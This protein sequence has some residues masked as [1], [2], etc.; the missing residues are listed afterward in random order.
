M[1]KEENGICKSLYES[2]DRFKRSYPELSSA[3]K[4]L[5]RYP[6]ASNGEETFV[7]EY[8]GKLEGGSREAR[9]I[10]RMAFNIQENAALIWA[11]IKDAVSPYY[12]QTIFN[13]L[14]EEFLDYLKSIPEY[15][16]LFGSLDYISCDHCRS[17]FGP[18]AYFADLMRFDNTYISLAKDTMDPTTLMYRRPDLYK[19]RLDCANSNEMI[20]QIDLVNELL[21]SFIYNEYHSDAYLEARDAIFP[22]SLPFNRP[23][24]EIRSY[25]KRYN[26]SLYQ[27]YNTF[28]K[29]FEAH[30]F[31]E[32]DLELA[33]KDLELIASEISS[34][35]DISRFYGDVPLT[36]ID[37]LDNVEVFL[38][39]TRLTRAGLN[40]LLFQNLDRH[41]V[42]A[43]LSRLFFINSADNGLKP[44]S[45]SQDESCGYEKLLNLSPKK[46]DRI[47]RFLK[48]S[49]KLGWSFTDLDWALRSLYEP[50]APEK[51]LKFDGIKDYVACHNYVT[52]HNA[53]LDLPNLGQFTLEA[54]VCPNSS[55]K[56][57]VIDLFAD[58]SPSRDQI[59]LEVDPSNKLSFYIG[60][61]DNSE[62]KFV[63][64][65]K[66]ESNSSL[67]LGSFTHIALVVGN[68]KASIYINGKL[69]SE[70]ALIT[71]FSEIKSSKCIDFNIGRDLFDEYF[72][73]CIKDVRIWTIARDAVAIKE[74]RFRRFT[75]KE[76]DLI[77]YWPLVCHNTELDL[78]K[79]DQFTIEAWVCPDRS[80]KN[81]IMGI[82]ADLNP[83]NDRILLEVNSSNKLFFY[84]ERQEESE[85]KSVESN[86]SLP[87]GTFSHIALVVGNDEASIYIDGRLDAKTAL[88]TPFS[89]VKSG[90]CIDFNI[91]RDLFDE[92]FDGCIKD[93]RIWKIARDSTAIKEDRSNRFTGNEVDLIGY[94]PLTEGGDNVI[95]QPKWVYRDLILDPLPIWEED[96]H[97][98]FNGVDQ[99]LEARGVDI[100]ETREISI[101]A[102][103][104]IDEMKESCIICLSD[105]Y[106]KPKVA[107]KILN[108]S[109]DQG[110]LS[111]QMN[112]PSLQIN[113]P[114][115]PQDKDRFLIPQRKL[116][117]VCIVLKHEP[118]ASKLEMYINGTLSGEYS[119]P[120]Q[121]SM[122][123]KNGEINVGRDLFSH[124]FHGGIR[125]IRIWNLARNRDEITLNMYRPVPSGDPGLVGYWRL[126]EVEKEE[127]RDL[128]CCHN[129]LYLGGL[130]ADYMPIPVTTEVLPRTFPVSAKE[131]ILKFDGDNDV[132]AI[133][134]S[135]NWGLGRYERMT[136]ELW[137]KPESSINSDR[138]QIIFTQGDKEA[139]L[140][141]YLHEAYVYVL[142]W[143]NNSNKKSPAQ[144]VLKAQLNGNDWHHVVLTH[145]EFPQEISESDNTQ[146]EEDIRLLFKEPELRGYLDGKPMTSVDDNSN[147][148]VCKGYRLSS[149]GI[150]YLGGLG[151]QGVTRFEDG[152]SEDGKEYQYFFSGNIAD[153]RIWNSIKPADQIVR[154]GRIARDCYL[155]PQITDDLVTYMPMVKG[156]DWIENVF[157]WDKIPGKDN[158]ILRKFL[159]KKFGIGWVET[160]KIEK[161]DNGK[162][163]KV[164]AEKISLSLELNDEK[165][166]VILEIDDGR[167][168]EFIAKMENDELNIY[169]KDKEW[170]AFGW[171][172]ESQRNP[173]SGTLQRREMALVTDNADPQLINI[174]SHYSDAAALEWN[175]YSYSGRMRITDINAA[176]GVTFFSRHPEGI[177]QCYLLGHLPG[178]DN[179]FR[180]FAHPFDYTSDIE[181]LQPNT[182]LDTI[183]STII[184][185]INI[186]YCFEITVK[187]AGSSTEILAKIW[188]E[189]SPEPK[190]SLNAIDKSDIRIR[191]GTVGLWSS[192]SSKGKRQF[193]DLQVKDPNSNT[194]LLDKNF[195]DQSEKSHPVNWSDVEDRIKSIPREG[196]FKRVSVD[197][198][199]IAFGTDSKDSNIHSYYID[200]D[201]GALSWSNYLYQGRMRI[202]DANGSIGVTF[203]SRQPKEVDQYY[204]L[205]REGEQG[206]FKLFAHPKGVQSIKS[207]GPEKDK[208]DS[209][210]NPLPN[211]WYRFLIK[212]QDDESKM[213]IQ[214]K[215]WPETSVMPEAFQI[216]AYDDSRIRIRSGTV[217]VWASGSGSKYFNDLKVFSKFSISE[218]FERYSEGQDPL[219][220]RDTKANYSNKEDSSLFNIFDVG[221]RK[222]LGTESHE[223][224]IHSHYIGSDALNWSNYV[225]TGKMRIGD[226]GKQNLSGIGVT[227]GIGVTFLSN[228]FPD[229]TKLITY[230]RL[231]YDAGDIE[232]RGFHIAFPQSDKSLKGTV[233]S[234]FSPNPNTWYRF[235]IE[236]ED[237]KDKTIIK[238]KIWPESEAEPLGYQIDAYDDN[239]N[240]LK[241]GTVGVVT[242]GADSKYFDDLE[243][244][245][246]TLLSSSY[247][248]EEWVDVG[249]RVYPK[250]D[251]LF[252]IVDLSN[253]ALRWQV[254]SNYPVLLHPL[255]QKA[256]E[257]DGEKQYLAAPMANPDLSKFTPESLS[258]F[259]LESWI[260]LSEIKA[261]PII[262]LSNNL[263]GEPKTTLK[264][265][266]D[267]I[268]FGTDSSGYLELWLKSGDQSA[269]FKGDS[270]PLPKGQFIHVAVSV[271]ASDATGDR[272][273]FFVDGEGVKAKASDPS[274]KVPDFSELKILRGDIGRDGIGRHFYGKIKEVRI[275]NEALEKNKIKFQM[276][277]RPV[278]SP[279][280]LR[281]W[282]L[283]EDDK[284]IVEDLSPG[285]NPL[286]LGT[287]RLGGM[288]EDR[289]PKLQPSKRKPTMLPEIPL[290]A[291][292]LD[293]IATFKRLKE[294]YNQPIDRL[295][296]LWHSIN[297]VG[298]DGKT[299]LFDRIFNPKGSVIEYWNYFMDEP[300]SWD[301]TG[302]KDRRRDG[303]IRSRLMGALRVS[304]D[305]LNAIVEHISGSDENTIDID[306]TYLWRMYQISGLAGML[307]L[308]VTDLLQLLSMIK[309]DSLGSLHDVAEVCDLAVWASEAGLS[310]ADLAYLTHNP[311]DLEGVSVSLFTEDNIKSMAVNLA[312]QS[313]VTLI[314]NG[315]FA[316][317]QISQAQS[318]DIFDK[319]KTL[320]LIT[321]IG[322]VTAKYTE[323]FDLKDLLS[324]FAEPD[325]ENWILEFDPLKAE[326][327][328][329]KTGLG[330]EIIQRLI[331]HGFIDENG[332]VLDNPK[333]VNDKPQ[334]G[335]DNLMVIFDGKTPD[336][337]TI[338][339][340]SRVT[341][342]LQIRKALQ[343]QIIRTVRV[344]LKKSRD[345]F[346]KAVRSGILVNNGSFALDQISQAQSSDIFSLLYQ[347]LGL[348]TDIG[349]VTAKYTENYDLIDLLSIFASPDKENW[350]KEFDPLKA[351]LEQAETGLGDEI[352]Q[353]LISHGFIDKNG[354]VL[355][356]PKVMDDKPQYGKDNLMVIFDGKTPDEITINKL[357]R[358]VTEILE[359]R[360]ALQAE[361]DPILSAV[362]AALK[363]SRDDLYS[364]I[365]SELANIFN[366]QVGIISVIFDYL[367]TKG[368]PDASLFVEKMIELSDPNSKLPNAL[369]DY[370]SKMSKLVY[371]AGAFEMADVEMKTLLSDPDRFSIS[372][373][374]Q[375]TF[376]DL[377]NLHLFKRLQ[378]DFGDTEGKLMD[379]LA[380]KDT[381]KIENALDDLAGWE[382]RQIKSLAEH[383]V[384]SKYNTIQGLRH[385]KECFDL[386][387]SMQV[388]V[389]YLLQIADTSTLGKEDEHAFYSKQSLGLLEILRAGY[390]DEE[391]PKVYGPIYGEL[392][393]KR[394]DALLDLALQRLPMY[395]E[396]YIF[397]PDGIPSMGSE[398]LRIFLG[399]HL[400]L[401]WVEGA[402]VIKDRDIITV[403]N[404]FELKNECL[405]WFKNIP[406]IDETK[407][408]EY[409]KSD[410]GLDWTEDASITK[411]YVVKITNPSQ[412]TPRQIII[413]LDSAN[414]KAILS[415]N[416]NH[417]P[418]Q[419]KITPKGMATTLSTKDNRTRN[420]FT[421][422]ENG[423][424]NVYD[425]A[426]KYLFSWKDIPGIDETKLKE[427][428]KSDL[429]LDWAEDASIT[430]EDVVKITNP[431]QITPR[432]IT[433]YLDSAN[434][435]A[436]LSTNDNHRPRQVKIT[437]KGMATTLSTNDNRTRNLFTK[438]ENG[439]LNVYDEAG[440]Y[441]FSWKDIPC[442]SNAE[443]L[444]FLKN[445]L[446]L[447]WVEGLSPEKTGETLTVKNPESKQ[448]KIT[449]D[450]TKVLGTLSTDNGLI[451][452]LEWKF[453][454]IFCWNDIPV[455]SNAELLAFLKNDLGL[456]WV[457]GLSPE[458]TGETLTVKNPESKQ[459]K[460]TLNSADDIVVLSTNDPCNP[461]TLHLKIKTENGKLNVYDEAGKYLFSW[462]D[463]P[464]N[465]NA[466]LLAFLKNDLGLSWVEGLSPE[467]TGETLT[468]ESKQVKITLNS[469][470]GIVVLSNN[471]PCNPYTL[472][473]KTKT[474]NG[475][476][477][478]YRTDVY[479]QNRFKKGADAFQEYFLMDMRVGS[480]VLTSRIVQGTAALQYYIQ[481]CLMNLEP[482][483][484]PSTIP[485]Q[486]WEW[487]KNYRVWEANRKVFLYPENYIEPELR[488]T[489]TPL[490][491]ELE[492]EL[493]QSDI[494][495]ESAEAAFT[496][497]LE[498]FAE[499]AN[500]KVVG[501]YLYTDVTNDRSA[502]PTDR[503]EVL[504]LIGRTNTN[505]KIYYR[506]EHI[507][508]DKGARWLPWKKIDLVINS[509]FAT[510]V[511]AFGKLFLF[512]T[513]FT[514][515][516]KSVDRKLSDRILDAHNA[517]SLSN[518]FILYGNGFRIIKSINNKYICGGAFPD[519]ELAELVDKINGV[520]LI[521]FK[522]LL[523]SMDRINFMS[524]I[525]IY[526]YIF[527]YQFQIYNDLFYE[528]SDR[529]ISNLEER[530]WLIDN[531]GYLFN[532]ETD[533]RVQETIDLYKT[534]VKYS[535]LNFSN[536]WIPPQNYAELENELMEMTYREP[537]WQR[538][539]AQQLLE[540]R[541]EKADQQQPKAETD[542][543]VLQIDES[544]QLIKSIPEFDMS[545]LTW[546]FWTK[547][548]NA[549][550]Q[551]WP[552]LIEKDDIVKFV[553]LIDYDNGNFNV[554]ATNKITINTAYS[555]AKA[556]AGLIKEA[557]EYV[558]NKRYQEAVEKAGQARDKALGA[559]FVDSTKVKDLAECARKAAQN[560]MKK[561]SEASA[562]RNNAVMTRNSAIEAR[563]FAKELGLKPEEKERREQIAAR[564]E[565]D[566]TKLENDAAQLEKEAATLESIALDK[567]NEVSD[568]AE[569]AIKRTPKW[570]SKAM[571]VKV[572]LWGGELST[573]LDYDTWQH[574]AIT[575]KEN[576][577]CYTVTL[578]K[579]KDGAEIS[580]PV[581]LT[582]Q[583]FGQYL[584]PQRMLVI[585][586]QESDVAAA[587]TAQMSEFRLWN[588]A[589]DTV[590]IRDELNHR[591]TGKEEGL[592]YLPLNVREA[593]SN[594]TLVKSRGLNLTIPILNGEL[595]NRIAEREHIILFYGDR[596]A[597]LRNNL[598]DKSFNLKLDPK[599]QKN[600][601]DLNLS[602]HQASQDTLPKAVFHLTD[603]IGLSIN[604]FAT[605]EEGTVLARPA[606]LPT[607]DVDPQKWLLKNLDGAESSFADVNNQPGW[608]IVDVGDEQFL[609]KAE[610]SNSDGNTL[611]MPTMAEICKMNYSAADRLGSLLP[612]SISYEL[613]VDAALHFPQSS[614]KAFKFERLNTFAVHELSENLFT[615]GID[616]LLSLESQHAKELHFWEEYG[617]NKELIPPDINSIPNE[618]DFQGAY[619]LYFEEIFFHVPFLIANKL[620]SNQKFE[621][622]QKWYHYIFNPTASEEGGAQG[623]DKDRYWRYL[624]FRDD[625]FQSLRTL[626][627]DEH[628]LAAY[629]EDPFDP[630]AIAALRMTAYKKA[631]VM[632]YI[633]NLLDWGDSLFMQDTRE[634]IN[635][636]LGLY[637]MAYDLL[638]PRPKV[639][640]I[641]RF[642]DIGTYEDFI[643][644]YRED[645]EFLTAVEKMFPCNCNS[646]TLSPHSNIITDF[647]VPENEKFIGYWD[648]VEDRLFKIRHSLNFEGIS[649]Q[650]ALFAPP[651]EP[652]ELVRALAGGASISGALSA[653]NVPVPHY[654]YSFM[655]ERAKDMASNVMELG[656]AL[657]GA[658]ESRDAEQLAILQNTH[659]RV[660]LN[661]MTSIKENEIGLAKEAI[662]A[663][664][665]SKK[666]PEYK[667]EWYQTRIDE[668]M[669]G[670]EIAELVLIGVA[671]YIKNVGA[672]LKFL[673]AATAG[674]PHVHTGAA[675]IASPFVVTTVG[676]SNISKP[677]G[678]FSEGLA[679]LADTMNT[680]ANM[681]AK[682]GGYKRRKAGWEFEKSLAEKELEEIEKQIVGAK[683]QLA[684]A[685]QELAIHSKTVQQN[686]EIERFYRSKF[687]NETL[688]SWMIGRLSSLY[689]QAYKLAYDMAKSAEKA[690]QYE[691][692]TNET[693]IT[694]G[695]WDSLKKGLL[696]GE[697]LM[698][699]LNRMEKSHLDQDSRFQEIEK[700]ISMKKTCPGSLLLLV[701]AG[702][703]EFRLN[704]ELFD[705]DYPGHYFR[706][707]KS[708][709][710][711]IKTSNPKPNEY[712]CESVNATL[713]QLGNKTLLDPDI[714]AVE[715]LMG[716]SSE[717]PNSNTLRVNWRANQQIA[718][719]RVDK[720]DDGMFVL[721]FFWDDRYFPF[722][723]TGA[724]SSW[725]LEIPH[726]SNPDLMTTLENVPVLDIEDVLIH[727]RYTAKSER[728]NFKKEI[729]KL[730]E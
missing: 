645:S 416:D 27:I 246:G 285:K 726:S 315:S 450:D 140:N 181:T 204:A 90:R 495:Q 471:D 203:L 621:E 643:C 487:V 218:S 717:Q 126:N 704:E 472:H 37:G 628:A 646:T 350:I 112:F 318:S 723:G 663:L 113:W 55:R 590:K 260:N 555:V 65:F 15:D 493:M 233:D 664:E 445:D 410:L 652:M 708:I 185:D 346:Y 360:K 208:T 132:I 281:Y 191:K 687:S 370:Y 294:A 214:A 610:F 252:S 396:E 468:V 20:P 406:G 422:P 133:K 374:T 523:K 573:E 689:F 249:S 693:Y 728:G 231:L 344:A 473:L 187:D 82:L 437:S 53:E 490:F 87:L 165:T 399:R 43:R 537:R 577:G 378:S 581:S 198:G 32:K 594:M 625:N 720:K 529:E 342:V 276:Y 283:G 403:T 409:L 578:H 172:K 328:K 666:S 340:L 149:V 541:T 421:K 137:F 636:A 557:Q 323:N 180:L 444:G 476:T 184:P 562:A 442:N 638:G 143:N 387:G 611:S 386:A 701:A 242:L 290:D 51:V 613:P 189:D 517:L 324:I 202:S 291:A 42:N 259:T 192:G 629:R 478:V 5:S 45:I 379:L 434:G 492:Q 241:S 635:E 427:Y 337:T 497:Y 639:K 297:H 676:G 603:T 330:D 372:N 432:Q 177:D 365:Q 702:A 147:N 620:N 583:R 157:S 73:G 429:G 58:C 200:K 695:H 538:V 713:I 269:K 223:T 654:R 391:W 210:I 300:I 401:D 235:K 605:G 166:E 93:V 463:I 367:D 597:S 225:Y 332:I 232:K 308:S 642:Q 303:Q 499:I 91:G 352:I 104:S 475:K 498:K 465:S 238:A 540:L 359:H 424:L 3:T 75:D 477:N 309:K 197:G 154:D 438:P 544:N 353:R 694:P 222:V 108:E 572:Q 12:S 669:N 34:P 130:Q 623:K 598:K 127:A 678:L 122:E 333:A 336:A 489:K 79:L 9:K 158:G 626:L 398:E 551:G 618:I 274:T 94:W 631:V 697:S 2:L 698:L 690:L 299:P 64:L 382:P 230:Y 440:K 404:S 110:L 116:T 358:V 553:K 413:S 531:E 78:F 389:D 549:N 205:C 536:E 247:T 412:I 508:D 547:F 454:Y 509:D 543:R 558:K 286:W 41:E 670:E 209:G 727:I 502:R 513:E 194:I 514:K 700:T 103:I 674:I 458:K 385:L 18:A 692:P 335:K 729:E 244:T 371:M 672:Y 161:I 622:A 316:S 574:I 580:D 1:T 469:A 688:Y 284:D 261:C 661:L 117:H 534:A 156:E 627:T 148:F 99:Y 479:R 428:L 599:E 592:F 105:D 183:E 295:I 369:K 288:E 571:T 216:D 56:N 62:S 512:W 270:N 596:I 125:E 142:E 102:W 362:H 19:I 419:V 584:P 647:C 24:E 433:I 304:N 420:L 124:Y 256:L 675:G 264:E 258:Q 587:F 516:T 361:Y 67:S 602:Y 298:K 199:E 725:R 296:A 668:Y 418:R 306:G 224:R 653:L 722:E 451:F 586:N 606:K 273:T 314:N 107:L 657:L 395:W 405:N 85:P 576:N 561:I 449:L 100:A 591:K 390:T 237:A 71:P 331:S 131:T 301:K 305:E 474:E 120:T 593:G 685:S 356:K 402:P 607:T 139:G 44:L 425:E 96:S 446:G 455:N 322:A 48:L 320:G 703:C 234:K 366:A 329:A 600:I 411:E 682:M 665:I 262:S 169:E 380:L 452:D 287:M 568:A 730:L 28:A 612:L 501:S 31:S 660:T 448:V 640:T 92:Y 436:I 400:K 564:I 212:V 415:T 515:L 407:L 716:S 186:W 677:L 84:I 160:A 393:E 658:I 250:N 503:D 282:S 671:Q 408:K 383:F 253:N 481:R 560:A 604:D 240:R 57:V 345:D 162:T 588:H 373:L 95:T 176:V 435:K 190:E 63:E 195:E 518:L 83:S 651:I 188:P 533:Q 712:E 114:L 167:K 239:P 150:A 684:I 480:E 430:K 656:S 326:L 696:A 266:G 144:S 135:N 706:V 535:Y 321:G 364:A 168:Y 267:G 630:H 81:V 255:S 280:L 271:K 26:T 566:A 494:T 60:R 637:I 278:V 686:Q 151:Q 718:I 384:I 312:G 29:P 17:I 175:N 313:Y 277:Q 307:R 542:I 182:G 522:V 488:D 193:D 136:L 263:E 98:K 414:G 496:H 565:D 505:P 431:S 441:L 52:C 293:D 164:Y 667:I 650:L 86:S 227:G 25:L 721:N 69:D 173:H 101:E 155:A 279:A 559:T 236:V 673:S 219:N 506:R 466:E 394:R 228:Y 341:E 36:G 35:G 207:S 601:Y 76:K 174:Y 680:S 134:N 459:V 129:D 681:T 221:G 272:V 724:V 461:Y 550:Y 355:D 705:R 709:E 77:G 707:I 525:T 47:Y 417:R 485:M 265:I 699:E 7:R 377:D 521:W 423:K 616:K 196:L 38:E 532:I 121:V 54:W 50:Y 213:M 89:D 624:P 159:I 302:M 11:N 683:I 109:N 527:T 118:K 426:G 39:Q 619:R 595:L 33:P 46:L 483:V 526:N 634:S 715:Y 633:D 141:I 289:R 153:L 520:A 376:R 375:P 327:E 662:A 711:Y 710:I 354:I 585:G 447:S 679:I 368:E 275:W 115:L 349:A 123:I 614:T 714:G 579:H 111:L 243:V 462:K 491:E 504:Y 351:E 482:G 72:D 641:K 644:D 609:V 388:G 519:S 217:G 10:Y 439:K 552:D 138:K 648:R 443:L 74:D 248:L 392:A 589:R 229:Q 310:V 617:T 254:D 4:I 23:L 311:I 546:E 397:C 61:Q 691:L 325:K 68:G 317:D 163:V 510:P 575:L 334:Y 16:R 292:A 563:K 179:K 319:L 500:L 539:Y 655:L 178:P 470:D 507:K 226:T 347:P 460:I 170:I 146:F 97:L 251:A 608:Y 348:I 152:Y 511:Y 66:L 486:E 8:A 6:T 21:E 145:K 80:R 457:E 88:K 570:E 338:N 381:A 14:P 245:G 524:L 215:I 268:I 49:H 206:T 464:G 569:E 649:R 106:E 719:S 582:V 119:L 343:D 363:K 257:F 220:W 545:Q 484:D 201:K 567:V 632:K 70:N 171:P 13:N 59:L 467:K 456:S 530:K 528:L 128:S 556:T 211:T 453:K 548:A 615:G 659:E 357:S 554:I 40:E 30:P 339:K 22:Q